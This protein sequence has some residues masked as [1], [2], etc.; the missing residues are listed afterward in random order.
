MLGHVVWILW[1]P[2][3]AGGWLLLHKA[4]SFVVR[5]GAQAVVLFF[6]LSGFVIHLPQARRAAAGDQ[7]P[8]D[9]L[10][11]LKRRARR[12]YPPLLFALALTLV[13]DT[14]G[15]RVNPMLYAGD[16]A[17]SFDILFQQS[18]HNWLTA[19]GNLLFVQGLLVN[20]F[21]TNSPLTTL[22][23]EAIFYLSYALVYLPIYRRFGPHKAFAIGLAVSLMAGGVA[24]ATGEVPPV[25]HPGR[26]WW[27]AAYYG[28]WL[29]GA[30]LADLFARGLHL[31]QPVWWMI[32]S[33]AGL[34]LNMFA[35]DWGLPYVIRDWM[36]AAVFA[37]I[38]YLSVEQM[39]ALSRP[40]ALLQRVLASA[41]VL[42][43]LSYTLYVIHLPLVILVAGIWLANH[44]YLPQS[45]WLAGGT[46]LLIIAVA[47]LLAE[48][49]EKP[50]LSSRARQTA[51]S[52]NLT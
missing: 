5:Y 23:Y 26:L 10:S 32:A 19:V 17:Y 20:R 28:M 49:I 25:G 39:A 35:R 37:V 16:I 15:Q 50:F 41:D 33:L 40:V 2:E 6:L 4:V 21:G 36:W 46:A 29:T 18:S 48:F 38:L 11:F 14:I 13:V 44:P 12:L 27:V 45:I 24:V 52:K 31:P 7:S 8:F 3:E 22:A 1:R 43:F 42:G 30:W 34:L 9:I 51:P 47:R